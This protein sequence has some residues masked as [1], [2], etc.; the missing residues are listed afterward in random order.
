MKATMRH[1]DEAVVGPLTSDAG[2]EA[3]GERGVDACWVLTAEGDEQR[4]KEMLGKSVVVWRGVAGRRKREER[5]QCGRRGS[6]TR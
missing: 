3:E 2:R 5:G 1:E 4:K 6:L